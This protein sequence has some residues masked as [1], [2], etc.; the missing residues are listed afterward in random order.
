MDGFHLRRVAV[1]ED[2]TRLPNLRR[3]LGFALRGAAGKL[4][5]QWDWH[6]NRD[7]PLGGTLSH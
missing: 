6:T 2:P 4:K 1:G 5:L 7:A 3:R